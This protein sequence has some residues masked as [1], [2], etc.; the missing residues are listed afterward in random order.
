MCRARIGSPQRGQADGG[1]TTD[2]PRGTR[3]TTTLRKEPMTSPSSPARTATT[4][5]G[6]LGHRCSD[7]LRTSILRRPGSGRAGPLPQALYGGSV[8]ITRTVRACVPP[9]GAGGLLD[10]D[11]DLEVHDGHL[12]AQ[13]VAGV[14]HRDQR[15]AELLRRL[16]LQVHPRG[17][18]APPEGD[19]GGVERAGV[20]VHVALGREGR[21]LHDE[22]AVEVAAGSEDELDV[23]GRPQRRRR[24]GHRRA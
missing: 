21:A 8:I 16:R 24:V 6:M 12:G 4:T 17:D 11:V 2:S 15:I 13:A 18:E 14:G 10:A 23:L 3:W 20:E 5:G 7:Q 1:L 9:R 19:Q 22:L